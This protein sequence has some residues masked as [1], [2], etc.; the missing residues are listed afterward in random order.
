MIK[1]VIFVTILTAILVSWHESDAQ[2]LEN[3]TALQ[4]SVQLSLNENPVRAL[5]SL[6]Q[7][8]INQINLDTLIHFI[9]ILSGEDSFTINDSTYL[10]FSR[11]ALHPQNDL[12]ADYIF[13]TLSRFGL[14][15][16]NQVFSTSGRNVY[17]VQTGTDYPDQKF[18]VCAH[19]DNMPIQSPAPGADDNASGVAAVL[20]AARILSQIPTPYTLIFALWDEEEIGLFGSSNFAQQASQSGEEILGVINLDMLGWDG[21]NDRV[22]EVHTQP[23]ANSLGLA[24]LIDSL[25]EYYNIGLNL[26]IH[27]PGTTQSDHSS[28]WNQGY[29]SVLMI[30]AFY[31]GDFNPYLHTPDDRIVNFNLD[32][33]HAQTRLTVATMSHLAFYNITPVSL[34]SPQNT[35]LAGFELQQNY[36]NP[37]N[38]ITVIS[39]QLAVGSPVKL[40]IYNAV[41]QGI[42]TLIDEEQ[43]AG[44]YSIE[45][46]AS[47]LSSGVYL[48]RLEA[49]KYVE[50]RKMILM[51]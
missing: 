49:G 40:S 21:N 39:Y 26:V 12:A 33:F 1:G 13:Q 16:F 42:A 7:T 10:L 19:Y 15:S 25:E 23:I 37:F 14:P 32:Y 18:V 34:E 48:Y 27:N 8:L 36:P 2:D 17:S 24:N 51:R 4:N 29:S 45:F 3:L 9:N 6:I 11:N 35:D 43:M 50:V 41:G 22:M 46:N 30:E 38:P 31:D 47:N 28:F 20:E 44:N 5:D